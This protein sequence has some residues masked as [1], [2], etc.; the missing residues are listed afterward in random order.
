MQQGHSPGMQAGQMPCLATAGTKPSVRNT[1]T[2]GERCDQVRVTPEMQERGMTQ[3]AAKVVNNSFLLKI[4]AD[5]QNA[6]EESNGGFLSY[7]G[8]KE[9]IFIKSQN[10]V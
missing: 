10:Y 1:D 4:S 7:C 8:R 2:A 6:N 5:I 3:E 9:Y